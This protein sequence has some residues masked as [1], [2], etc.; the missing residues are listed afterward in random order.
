VVAHLE[1]HKTQVAEWASKV[2]VDKAGTRVMEDKV[3]KADIVVE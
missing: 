1:D 2:M 3:I